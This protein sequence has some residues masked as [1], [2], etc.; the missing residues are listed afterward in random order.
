MSESKARPE[1]NNELSGY[2]RCVNEPYII[3][4]G[5]HGYMYRGKRRPHEQRDYEI[6]P[7]AVE[8]HR[9]ENEPHYH[10]R[11]HAPDEGKPVAVNV[12]ECYID[13]NED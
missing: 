8:P 12:S 6:I 7:S 13:K 5:Q 4:E 3:I 11:R 9:I 10:R 1:K 2:T